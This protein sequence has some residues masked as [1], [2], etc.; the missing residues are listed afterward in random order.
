MVDA[1]AG[2]FKPRVNRRLAF[3]IGGCCN[4]DERTLQFEGLA[5]EP[6]GSELERVKSA[7]YEVF[8]DGRDRL[9]WPGLTYVRVTPVW[10]RYSDY[11][12]NPPV[13]VEFS[14]GD[15]DR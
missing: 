15:L 10:V 3:V 7:Y 4:G 5:D 9:R 13:V 12:V 1:T 11:N 2:T 14:A 6:T 8:P